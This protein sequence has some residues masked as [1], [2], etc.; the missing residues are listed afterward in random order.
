MVGR[1]VRCRVAQGGA[2][3]VLALVVSTAARSDWTFVP[4]ASVRTAYTDNVRGVSTGEEADFFSTYTAGIAAI[5]NGARV[6]ANLNYSASR[7]DFS[8]TDDLGGFR[9]NLLANGNVE[10]L[11]DLLFF[12]ASSA[13]SRQTI[14]RNAAISGTNR[15][16]NSNQT[17]VLN[18]S[19]GPTVRFALGPWAF[20]ETRYRLSG[21]LFDPFGSISAATAVGS[22]DT[23]THAFNQTFSNG[24]NFDRLSWTATASYSAADTS[25]DPNA[26]ITRQAQVRGVYRVTRVVSVIASGG[27]QDIQD[28]T[29]VNDS[30]T[31]GTWTV[32]LQLT[33]GP[34]TALSVEYGRRFDG[35]TLVAS[36][37]YQ[38]SPNLSARVNFN[39]TVNI[40]QT[41]AVSNFNFIATD[42]FGNLIDTRTNLPISV[43]D[44]LF[45]QTDLNNVFKSNT[46]SASLVGTRGRNNY[47][48]SLTYSKRDTQ[49]TGREQKVAGGNITY[50]R[51]LRPGITMNV[52]GGYNNITDNLAADTQFLN[53]GANLSYDIAQNLNG[54][55]SYSF[56]DRSSSVATAELTENSVSLLLRYTF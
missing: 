32:G 1:D 52:N 15:D 5:G 17:D 54:S 20:S 13:F 28:N 55:L 24:R 39:E 38:F 41:A 56:I 8:S 49:A 9:Q 11:E 3:L 26:F 31:G 45:D 50:G 2:I 12:N 48:V 35:S 47:T 18:Y 30:L 43:D 37:S 6:Q 42:Q 29:I 21:T 23:L 19:V 7:E 33:P 46:L 34:R 14:N 16:L 53:V 4:Q 36:G 44:P 40:Q 27:Y 22:N 25:G 10:L 51:R